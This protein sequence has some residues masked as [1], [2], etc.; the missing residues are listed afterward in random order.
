NRQ[1][2]LLRCRACLQGRESCSSVIEPR[3][4]RC[5]P[6]GYPFLRQDLLQ[7][8]CVIERNFRDKCI[9]VSSLSPGSQGML[10]TVLIMCLSSSCTT[11]VVAFYSGLS[12]DKAN[13][14]RRDQ[15]RSEYIASR[16]SSCIDRSELRHVL[17][18]RSLSLIRVSVIGC[19]YG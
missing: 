5:C 11:H 1:N 2:I 8:G 17:I 7:R 19:R 12:K 4:R 18:A 6:A 15:A 14:C 9:V 3:F 16:A 13:F 10:N